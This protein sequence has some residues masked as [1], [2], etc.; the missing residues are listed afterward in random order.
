MWRSF[1]LC[2]CYVSPVTFVENWIIV[3]VI[4]CYVNGFFDII[5]WQSVAAEP[6]VKFNG[7]GT[8]Y[9]DDYYDRGTT[10]KIKKIDI[11]TTHTH[12]HNTHTFRHNILLSDTYV[13]LCS[14]EMKKKPLVQHPTHTGTPIKFEKF[15][16]NI[17][18]TCKI[19]ISKRARDPA[20]WTFPFFFCFLLCFNRTELT[21]VLGIQFNSTIFLLLLYLVYVSSMY[22]IWC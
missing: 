21:F 5:L 22:I 10:T 7:C 2:V 18:K 17:C 8:M 4:V 6:L 11:C 15:R 1:F 12:I 9:N 13:R 19:N 16:I 3:D 14:Y 20:F